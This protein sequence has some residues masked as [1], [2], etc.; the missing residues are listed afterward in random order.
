MRSNLCSVSQASEIYR[1]YREGKFAEL[2]LWAR[3]VKFSRYFFG[4]YGVFGE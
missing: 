1:A 4:F 2:N 3:G